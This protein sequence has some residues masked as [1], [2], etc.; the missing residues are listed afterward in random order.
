MVHQV[1]NLPELKIVKPSNTRWLVHKRCVR[2]V[3]PS[4]GAIVTALDDIHEKNTHE[5]EA[6]CLVKL[7]AS[8]PQLQL[9]IFLTMFFLRRPN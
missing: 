8:S 5:P 7:S 6:L 9:S 4:Y 3:K 2:A 1:L